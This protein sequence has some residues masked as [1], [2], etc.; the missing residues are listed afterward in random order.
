MSLARTENVKTNAAHYKNDRSARVFAVTDA[1][2][3]S[4][5]WSGRVEGR[6]LRPRPPGSGARR[7]AAL[8]IIG[9]F[10]L[11]GCT[12]V[13][14]PLMVPSSVGLELVAEGLTSPLD[15]AQPDDGTNRLFIVDQIGL[16]RV[17]D[18]QGTL[19]PEPFLDLRD[20]VV[21]VGIDFGGG[22]IYDERGLLGLACHPDFATNCRFFVC[23]NTPKLSTD[24][25]EFDSRLRVSEFAVSADSPNRADPMSERVLLEI[26][27]PQFNHNG[28]QLVFGS[29][30]FLY[31]GI[32]DGGNANDVGDGHNPDIGNGQDLNT[33]LGKILRI[34]VD[35]GDPY[36][37]PADNPFVAD[38]DARPE[39]WAYGFRNPF[40]FSFDS[41]GAG[42]LF[43]GDVGQ[44]LFE[45]VDI[46]QRG[47]NYGWHIR[48]GAHC[49]DPANPTTPPT[50]CPVRGARG[51]PLLEP[52][53]EIPHT[54]EQG[55][56]VGIAVQGG[57]VYRGSAVSGLEGVYV[58]GDF[59]TSFLAADGTLFTAVENLDGSWS[60]RELGIAG[61]PNGRLGRFLL[62]LGRDLS[63]ELYV[64][65][66]ANL[67]PAGE[68]GQVYRIVSASP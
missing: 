66:T 1:R 2:Q 12:P 22:F 15:L 33:L 27:K 20:R 14:M 64:L 30:G 24:P 52:I 18:G 67:A 42:R 40:R 55:M 54:D 35:N 47:G 34:D 38:P 58:F 53:V 6:S 28:G 25:E 7:I 45:E 26:V 17:V 21:P 11:C 29:D 41:G 23:Y 37:I 56:P 8:A 5:A 49:F 3:V 43:V 50:D 62:A 9:A 63:G 36:G 46:V 51:E 16:V 68:T 4:A 44:D 13:P 65:T 57:F 31:F 48:E 39:V 32:G 61:R 60:H 10:A 59:S 19:L